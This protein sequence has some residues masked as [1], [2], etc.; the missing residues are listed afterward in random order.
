MLVI[1]HR[2]P[3]IQ[4]TNFLLSLQSTENSHDVLQEF[5]HMTVRGLSELKGQSL[6]TQ[7]STPFYVYSLVAV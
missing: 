4:H 1:L 3:P 2:T 6:L 7:T 5:S